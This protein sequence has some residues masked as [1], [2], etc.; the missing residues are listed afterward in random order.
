MT[1]EMISLETMREQIL[2]G[3]FQATNHGDYSFIPKLYA[4]S[5]IIHTLDGD[6]HG[7][8]VIIDI[9][10]KWK[11]A[12]PDFQLEPLCS[13]QESDVLV[14]HWRAKGTFTNSIRDIQPTGKKITIHGFTCFKCKDNQV[15]EHWARVDYRPLSQ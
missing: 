4:P 9:F 7:S 6:K 12:L 5:A 2:Q 3:F 11:M 8:D 1:I 13:I 10:R 15:V 14:I